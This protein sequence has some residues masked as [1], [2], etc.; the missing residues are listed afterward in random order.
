MSEY[1]ERWDLQGKGGG[2]TVSRW[3]LK[4]RGMRT[5]SSLSGPVAVARCA[6]ALACLTVAVGCEADQEPL[7]LAYHTRDSAGIVIAEHRG[8]PTDGER[9]SVE[10]EPMVAIGGADG[11]P[12]TLFTVVTMASRLSDGTIVVLENETSE[13]R[14]FDRKARTGER[15]EGSARVRESSSTGRASSGWPATRFL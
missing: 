8:V 14:F 2:R 3:R 9:W 15:R 10:P 7:P 11:P 6:L 4:S 1:P 12:A 5:N 13:L